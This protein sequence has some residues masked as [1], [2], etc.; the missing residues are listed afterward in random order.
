MEAES[1]ELDPGWAV[2]YLTLGWGYPQ[3][4]VAGLALIGI[5]EVG[6]RRL[7]RRSTPA[8][9]ARRRRRILVSYAGVVV[10]VGSACTP[11]EFWSMEYFWVHMLQHLT[12]MLAAPALY[13]AGDPFLALVFAV[14]VDRRRRVLR[15]LFASSPR[16][17][18]ARMVRAATSPVLAVVSFNLVMVVWM[19]PP[20]FNP[21]MASERL[22]ISLMLTSFFV[23]GALFWLQFMP[24]RPFRP[25]LSPY[26]QVAA[27]VVS[28]VV[29]IL[30]A[31]SISFFTTAPL[32]AMMTMTTSTAMPGM[33]GMLMPVEIHRTLSPVADQQI[34][35]GIL[36]VCGD[37]WAYPALVVSLR[38]MISSGGRMPSTL[39][40]LVGSQPI[41]TFRGVDLEH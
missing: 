26:G 23:S 36:W 31:M 17:V 14:P 3:L 39:R 28:N 27:L 7:I 12:V 21:V 9:A 15:R 4:A 2:Q 33:P 5:H 30:I 1:C 41:T 34:G 40:R 8:H 6:V 19:I 24:S 35:A 22:H 32:Y 13:L 18:G 11:L 37:L 20:L 38:R 25:R 16:R 10:G 29:M